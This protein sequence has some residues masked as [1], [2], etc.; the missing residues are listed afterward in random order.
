[1]NMSA[2]HR[3]QYGDL[4]TARRRTLHPCR[5]W[6][7][8]L[9]R[10]AS[11]RTECAHRRWL[12]AHMRAP[13]RLGTLHA[14]WLWLLSTDSVEKLVWRSGRVTPKFDLIKRPLLN[15]TQSGDGFR[16]PPNR[17]DQFL[18]RVST[19]STAQS[20]QSSVCG[21]CDRLRRVEFSRSP[22][23]TIRHDESIDCV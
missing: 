19:E 3:G 14:P 9:P 7:L 20:A 23:A 18:N 2:L 17:V 8:S 4:P 16:P 15:A 13:C 10:R 11:F 6:P 12:C 22:S 21:N 5:R 1:C